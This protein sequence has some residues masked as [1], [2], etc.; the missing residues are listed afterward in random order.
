MA[1]DE[2]VFRAASEHNHSFRMNRSWPSGY[3]NNNQE[4]AAPVAGLCHRAE[5]DS[6]TKQ[7]LSLSAVC[8]LKA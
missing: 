1:S 8:P 4:A 2:I 7:V 5:C 3:S 6:Q